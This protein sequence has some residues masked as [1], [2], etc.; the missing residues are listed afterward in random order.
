MG[1]EL[2]S[3]YRRSSEASWANVFINKV[4]AR[5]SS[6]MGGALSDENEAPEL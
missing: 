6:Y 1:T 5:Q 3:G 4:C 2:A